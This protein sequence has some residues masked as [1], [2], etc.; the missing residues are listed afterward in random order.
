M[1]WW[2]GLD[3]GQVAD[4]S[5]LA[6]IERTRDHF[7]VRHVERF[8]IGTP[9]PCV[10]AQ[11]RD[12]VATPALAGCTLLPDATGVGRAV[13][14]LLVE[15]KIS[16]RIIPVTITGGHKP[17]SDGLGGV[18]VPKKDLVAV[19]KLALQ[20]QRLHIPASLPMAQVLVRELETHRANHRRQRDVR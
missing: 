10:V 9:Y 17:T 6:C 8:A 7:A 2:V 1:T 20:N 4:Y 18:H 3:L 14:D 11:V 15:S 13:V 19:V 12:L 16:S 5:A